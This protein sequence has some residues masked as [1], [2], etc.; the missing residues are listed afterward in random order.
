MKQAAALSCAQQSSGARDT[1][2]PPLPPPRH[3][4]GTPD[5]AAPPT[6]HPAPPPALPT[7][8][9]TPDHTHDN[10]RGGSLLDAIRR[11]PDH[12]P[13]PVNPPQRVL[14]ALF[15]SFWWRK[16]MGTSSPAGQ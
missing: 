15:S 6:T 13:W 12:A 2:D 10:S 7:P 3:P 4:R 8:D 11:P 9:G 5:P 16:T 1:L 14:S